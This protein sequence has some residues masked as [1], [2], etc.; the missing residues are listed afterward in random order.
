MWEAGLMTDD[1]RI[2]QLREALQEIR[3]IA[4]VSDGVEFYAMLATRALNQ[5]DENREPVAI[6]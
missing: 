3:D 6:Q 5:D 1:Q 4:R 2:D